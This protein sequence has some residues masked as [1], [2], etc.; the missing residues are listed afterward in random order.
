VAS[1]EIKTV[2]N[3]MIRYEL[4]TFWERLLALFL[5]WTVMGVF[6][7]LIFYLASVYSSFGEDVQLVVGIVLVTVFVFY[8]LVSE[9]FMHGS[10][11]GKRILHL[12]IMRLDGQPCELMDYVIRWAFRSVDIFLSSGAA[13]ALL[14]GFSPSRQRIGEI[15]SNTVVVKYFPKENSV[16]QLL[17]IKSLANYTPSF[18]QSIMI[19]E[20]EAILIK[21]VLDRSK[22]NATAGH[23]QS[24]T[25][26]SVILAR[27]MG[28]PPREIVNDKDFLLAVLR[29]YVA[30]SR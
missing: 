25:E 26:L 23:R 10:S 1:I 7:T 9:Y 19:S 29:D 3:V 2:Q 18:A 12:R 15:L 17:K 21:E 20:S 4:G 30:L 6:A 14:V 28:I 13:V 22:A 27:K 11:I 5:D 16:S 8:S 24:I